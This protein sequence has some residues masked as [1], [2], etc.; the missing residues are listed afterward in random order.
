MHIFV[1]D[2][3][4]IESA[5]LWDITLRSELKVDRRFGGTCCLRLHC[6]RICQARIWHGA[7]NKQ[8]SI[9]QD[10]TLYYIHWL[11]WLPLLC[12][13]KFPVLLVTRNVNPSALL[14]S[15]VC[16]SS[17]IGLDVTSRRMRRISHTHSCDTTDGSAAQ[18]GTWCLHLVHG[19]TP[20]A[21]DQPFSRTTQRQNKR[22][23]ASV[24]RVG[25]QP[26][27]PVL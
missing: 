1:S 22:R 13:F 27:V 15:M 14:G 7:V 2:V 3:F 24:F 16:G 5:V 11:C 18:L 4:C 12:R 21:G 10:R 25:L 17:P 19:R 6:R 9:P 23:Q 8:S 26:T 20:R